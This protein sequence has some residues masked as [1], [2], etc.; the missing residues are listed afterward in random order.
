MRV[1]IQ[2][3]QVIIV[4]SFSAAF[5]GVSGACAQRNFR[6]SLSLF[7]FRSFCLF[8]YYLLQFFILLYTYRLRGLIVYVQEFCV[9][10]SGKCSHLHLW[11]FQAH[12]PSRSHLIFMPNTPT[13]CFRVS[14]L[15]RARNDWPQRCFYLLQKKKQKIGFFNFSW[16]RRK[17]LN[18]TSN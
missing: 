1:V 4:Y 9:F 18:E 13:T 2:T 16:S 11:P 14:T 5:G 3:H 10:W 6:S 17:K 7:F 12:K 8:S 15:F